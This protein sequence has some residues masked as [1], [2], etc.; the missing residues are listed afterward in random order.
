MRKKHLLLLLA[1]MVSLPLFAQTREERKLMRKG[2][3]V[4][5]QQLRQLHKKELRAGRL[6]IWWGGYPPE[7]GYLLVQDSLAVKY[8]AGFTC[9]GGCV[10]SKR[11]RR[12]Q[13]LHNK[14]IQ[15]KLTRRNGPGWQAALQNETHSVFTLYQRVL[16]SFQRNTAFYY[17]NQRLIDSVFQHI[18]YLDYWVWPGNGKDTLTVSCFK[19]GGQWNDWLVNDVIFEAIAVLPEN[20][21]FLKPSHPKPAM[22]TGEAV[23]VRQ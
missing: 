16:D 17:Q 15:K 1:I 6:H 18:T 2:D 5:A 19:R 11:E 23:I 21:F 20:R 3:K 7:R 12:V 22:K 10:R 13:N 14:K 8:G 4:A 9:A